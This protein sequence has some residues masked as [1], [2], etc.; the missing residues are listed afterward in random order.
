MRT[1]H[2]QGVK[3]YVSCSPE[4]SGFCNLAVRYSQVANYGDEL[5][6]SSSYSF[7]EF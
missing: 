4:G 3:P 2:E 7:I 5:C 6:F 1:S